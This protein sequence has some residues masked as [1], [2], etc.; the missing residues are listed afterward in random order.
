MKPD[1]VLYNGRVLA[2]T[3]A[4]ENGY[5]RIRNGRIS[6]IGAGM[7]PED[8][9]EMIDVK[10]QI[11]APGFIDMHTHGIK[12]VDFME[13][14]AEDMER[15]LQEY[16]RFGVTR[17][18]PTTLSNPIDRIIS[19][20]H[21]VRTLRE[22][23]PLGDMV[24]GGHMEGPWLAARCRGGHAF[25]YLTHPTKKDVAAIIKEI[26]DILISLTYAPELENSV[27]MT[28][29]IACHGILPVFGH[30]EAS[31]E[32]AEQ[33]I[34]AGARHVTHMYDTTLGYGENP[35]EALVMMPGMETAVLLDDRVSIELIGCP[36]HVPEP[37]FRFID[38]VKP[39]YKKI[40]VTDSLIGTGFPEHTEFTYEDGRKV[41]VEEGVLRMIDDDPKV[42]G[43][44]TGSAVTLNRGLMRL[45][46][47]AQ[48]PI[49]E[50]V[51]W[52]SI[53][54]AMTLGIAQ[55]TGSITIGKYADIA[56]LDASCKV[57]MTLLKGKKI[58]DAE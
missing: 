9:Q 47:Y 51:Q 48:L 18:V 41:Y 6:G 52:V 22:E 34:L 27:W 37:F 53:N 17:V 50:A 10:G 35:D 29:Q 2:E 16:A 36:I 31:F 40:L 57:Q 58:F 43:N 42:H 30:T 15:G 7:P 5:V 39:R 11:I 3:M 19:Q 4:I 56:V 14:S 13:A 23:S 38:K 46:E 45:M 44:L 33:A 12:D 8:A 49:E 54:P 24:P 1:L 25:E 21:R 55:E 20:M 32:D 28:E 26:G